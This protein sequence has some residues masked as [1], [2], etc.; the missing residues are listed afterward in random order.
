GAHWPA[1]RCGARGR[2]IARRSVA[3]SVGREQLDSPGRP[4]A[5]AREG[6]RA[7][8]ARAARARCE[9]R[10]IEERGLMRGFLLVFALHFGPEHPSGDSWF[11]PDKAKHFFTAAFVQTLSFGAL[12]ST[13]LS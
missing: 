10:R 6:D 7:D 12:R 4:P 5:P 11:A 2:A 9:R 8:R 13:G 1:V 3:A